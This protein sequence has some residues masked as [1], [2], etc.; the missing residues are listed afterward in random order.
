MIN[1]FAQIAIGTV[2]LVAV[3]TVAV[4]LEFSYPKTRRVAKTVL[5]NAA[6]AILIGVWAR[7]LQPVADVEFAFMRDRVGAAPIPLPEH[8][9]P[10]ILSAALLMFVADQIGRAHV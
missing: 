8:G 2:T 3:M 6:C 9:W 10:V 5:F 7:L 1:A 4:T